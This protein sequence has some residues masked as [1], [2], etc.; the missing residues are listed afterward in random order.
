MTDL[1]ELFEHAVDGDRAVARRDGG[2]A[3]RGDGIPYGVPDPTDLTKKGT[4]RL[5]PMGRPSNAGAGL[6]NAMPLA[7]HREGYL[8]KGLALMYPVLCTELGPYP[9][10]WDLGDERTREVLNT[11]LVEG[12]RRA[13]YW[14]K[15][16]RGTL[17][18]KILHRVA[19]AVIAGQTGAD[20]ELGDLVDEAVELGLSLELLEAARSLFVEFFAAIAVPLAAEVH[21]MHP[22]FRKLGTAD[23]VLRWLVDWD[24]LRVRTG[25]VTGADLK[26]GR[27]DELTALEQHAQLGSYFAAG[28]TMYVL[29]PVDMT[30]MGH[31]EP[32][33][34]PVRPDR[35]VIVHLP[36]DDAIAVG[37]L[38]LELV[39][40]DLIAS[41][42]LL[43]LA[44][45]VADCRAEYGPRVLVGRRHLDASELMSDLQASIAA[46]HHE[47]TLEWFHGRLRTI[48]TFRPAL[49]TLRR[50]WPSDI[51]TTA[52][53]DRTLAPEH[54]EVIDR[55]LGFVEAEHRLPWPA[56]DPRMPLEGARSR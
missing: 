53:R 56:R 35:A 41:T 14:V 4:P 51:V 34:W 16:D 19:A 49:E 10:L 17:V 31:P 55:L 42:Y 20:V 27:V 39:G 50:L 23:L 52:V 46:V 8:A 33:P 24:E 40:V 54:V 5:K 48:S 11:A 44:R 29:D 13:G 45:E 21:A 22:H 12:L 3:R 47:R 7:R 37:D 2:I 9:E 30:D 6:A 36:I 25:D 26:S 43:E 15:A 18:H 32:W 1:D 38:R 28:S